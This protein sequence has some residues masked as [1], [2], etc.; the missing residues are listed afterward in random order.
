[1]LKTLRSKVIAAT[2]A[3]TALVSLACDKPADTPGN[4]GDRP[5]KNKVLIQLYVDPEH[6][7]YTYTM[8]AHSKSNP[9]LKSIDIKDEPVGSGSVKKILEYDQGTIVYVYVQIKMSKIGSTKAYIRMRDDTEPD[10]YRQANGG[11]TLTQ[12]MYTRG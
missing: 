2:V 9:K 3:A 1:M 4:A 8:F 5:K 6:S 10:V 11:W 7:P 12:D